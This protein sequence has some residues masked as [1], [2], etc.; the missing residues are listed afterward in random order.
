MSAFQVAVYYAAGT[1]LHICVHAWCARSD[2][3][4]DELATCRGRGS[5][6]KSRAARR[7]AG[8]GAPPSP[9]GPAAALRPHLS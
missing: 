3:G 5:E 1:V 2:G 7:E 6:G 8:S 9:R 4:T